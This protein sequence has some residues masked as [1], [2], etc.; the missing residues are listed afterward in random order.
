LPALGSLNAKYVTYLLKEFDMRKN[1]KS[2]ALWLGALL[3]IAA[4]VLA[5]ITT[6]PEEANLSLIQEP[7]FLYFA[8]RT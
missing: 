1:S 4:C 2:W 8:I 7:S 3:I 5:Y 6:K